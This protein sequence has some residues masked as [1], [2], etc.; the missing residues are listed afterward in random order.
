MLKLL[1]TLLIS[2]SLFAADVYPLQESAK[3]E[4]DF[5]NGKMFSRVEK[6]LD[7]IMN[8]ASNELINAGYILEGKSLQSEWYN[9]YRNEYEKFAYNRHDIGDH[10]DQVL[11][12]WLD[13]RIDQLTMLLGIQIMKQTHLID[14][15]VFNDTIKIVF[16]PCTF[17]MN[18]IGG[19]RIDE[20]RKNFNQDS[21]LFGLFPVTS[22]WVSYVACGAGTAGTG[23][24]FVCGLVGDV[25][26]RV[27]AM[28]GGKLS[29]FIFTKSCGS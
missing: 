10:P 22:F 15:K 11:S 18:Q 29:D 12:V 7:A 28:V 21:L 1:V 20:Y 27:S 9:Q 4:Q 6:S 25:A 3:L 16:K 24:V 17:G 23:Y 5:L 19:N 8:V 13:Q 2:T 14:L 26:E